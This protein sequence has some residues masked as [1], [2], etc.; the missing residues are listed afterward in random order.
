M[1]K[2]ELAKWIYEATRLE[3]DWSRRKIV[4]EIWEKRD[5]KFRK[6]FVDIIDRYL[7]LEEL[8]TP[9]EAHNSWMK[10]YFA[11]GWKFGNERDC[12]KKIHPDLVPFYEL[13]RDERDKDAIFLVF[14]WLSKK[15]IAVLKEVLNEVYSKVS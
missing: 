3:A 10:A 12:I 13:P 9:E 2:E 15:I 11:M 6:Q 1:I 8:P 4:P 5:E 14:V 7:S